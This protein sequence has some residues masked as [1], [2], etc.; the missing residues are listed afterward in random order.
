MFF[1]VLVPRCK[2]FLPVVGSIENLGLGSR[3]EFLVTGRKFVH[4][5]AAPVSQTSGQSWC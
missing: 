4:L 5:L 1:P 3:V 2:W